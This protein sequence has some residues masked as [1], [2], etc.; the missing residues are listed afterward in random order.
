MYTK[1]VH[2]LC[3]CL[4]VSNFFFD[5]LYA[6]SCVRTM[7]EGNDERKHLP[8]HRAKPK[9]KAHSAFTYELPALCLVLL[10]MK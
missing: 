3:S 1:H 7:Y 2:D 8:K 5:L 6:V 4:R 9:D 10:C